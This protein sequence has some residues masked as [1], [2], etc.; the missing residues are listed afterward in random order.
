[1]QRDPQGKTESRRPD[2]SGAAPDLGE[3][4]FRVLF[5]HAPVG[6]VLADAASRYIDANPRACQLLG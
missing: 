5:D 4:R 6:V 2:D 3:I 1:M